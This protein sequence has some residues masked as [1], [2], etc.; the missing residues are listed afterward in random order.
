MSDHDIGTFR[1]LIDRWPSFVAMADGL[2]A[3]G[4]MTGAGAVKQWHRRN[5]IPAPYFE[6]VIAAARDLG[7]G[8]VTADLLV[9][10]AARK[11][12]EPAA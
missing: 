8:G 6:A 10:L 9:A 11:T 4:R 7:I 1:E 12:E 5:A 3:A 2:C